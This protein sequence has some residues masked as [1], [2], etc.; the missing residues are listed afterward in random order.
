MQKP[1][2][3]FSCSQARGAVVALGCW[4]LFRAFTHI[5]PGQLVIYIALG[6][7]SGAW[8]GAA[9]EQLLVFTTFS[10]GSD[11]PICAHL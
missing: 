6:A 11:A 9:L 4:L 8:H 2:L 10:A 3:G 5:E 7:M 1:M